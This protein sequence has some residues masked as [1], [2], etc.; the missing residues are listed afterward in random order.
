MIFKSKYGL[1][2]LSVLLALASM[3]ASKGEGTK[4]D[5]ANE[6][7]VIYSPVG[8]RDPFRPPENPSIGRQTASL[9]P[10]D[11]YSVE[12]LQ[13]RAILNGLGKPRAMFEDPDGKSYIVSEGQLIARE[14][15]TV[16]RIL[17]KGVILTQRTFNYLGEE[18]ISERVIS[19]DGPEQ[20]NIDFASKTKK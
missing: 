2:V 16:S 9:S 7:T 11:R 6:K 15:V 18:N 14:R 13:L 8:K 1:L 20:N 19:L 12:Q 3:G 4:S 10:I 5:S 17:S